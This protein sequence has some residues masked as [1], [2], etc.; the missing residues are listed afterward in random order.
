[1]A[2]VTALSTL[3][4]QVCMDSRSNE[5]IV[6][7]LADGTAKAGWLVG[8]TDGITAVGINPNGNLDELL[9]I[10]LP[11][12]NIDVDTAI[13]AALLVDIV[14]P[15]GGHLYNI[16][17]KDPGA[18]LYGGEPLIPISGTPGGLDKSGDIESEHIARLF[19]KVL[20]NTTYATVIWG[21]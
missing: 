17:I 5:L 15:Q 2:A 16:L 18:T 13:T 7:R 20:D 12:Y 9:G 3:G 4:G 19:D 1:M 6:S 11:R 21:V 14:I 10:L 8:C